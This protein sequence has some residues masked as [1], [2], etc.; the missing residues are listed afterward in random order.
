MNILVFTNKETLIKNIFP[1]KT[2]YFP[3]TQIQKHLTQNTDI[4]YVDVSGSSV[5]EINKILVNIKIIGGSIPW[6]IV[7]PKGIIKDPADIFFKGASDYI[8]VS[9]FKESKTIDSK[10][11]NITI[12]WRNDLLKTGS[13]LKNEN[14]KTEN[15][16]ELD[17][18]SKTGIKFPPIS[19]FPG[20]KKMGTS[21]TMPFF[22][23]YCSIQGN[24]PLESRFEENV[25]S[26]I[27]NRFNEM[28]KSNFKEAEGLLWIDSG[29]DCIFLFPPKQKTAEAIIEACFRT[30]INAPLIT[31]ETL[32]FKVPIN[33]VFALHYGSVTYKPPG[34]TGTVVS[35]AVNTVFHLGSMKA[36][37]GRLTI[38]NGL[39]DNSIP[40][41]FEDCFV[42]AGIFEDR[43]IWHSKKFSYEKPW[44]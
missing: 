23:L 19:T 9:F 36:K 4:F 20:W 10:R 31:L 37:A 26:Q 24:F 28:L 2:L 11:I 1:K 42:N 21:K 22:L 3:L 25:L 14:Q 12:Q 43:K 15:K 34:K 32:S 13:L 29:K 7:D 18:I 8:G 41:F 27:H 39:P 6:G 16:L 35:D 5:S 33:F 38:T 44:V 40:K 30:I 17:V